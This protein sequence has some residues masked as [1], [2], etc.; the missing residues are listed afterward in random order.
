MAKY[1]ISA[2]LVQYE[3]Y[4]VEAASEDEA[5]NEVIFCQAD[6]YE[7]TVEE[8]DI[9]SVTKDDAADEEIVGEQS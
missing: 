7:Y 6:A 2:R 3:D 4:Y 1:Y 5:I 8:I 9:T